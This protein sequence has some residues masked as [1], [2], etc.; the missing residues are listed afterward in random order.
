MIKITDQYFWNV[1]FLIFFGSLVVMGVIILET[2]SRF[3]AAGL[4]PL[5]YI[6]MILATWRLVRLFGYDTITKFFRE[7]FWDLK[8]VG[9]GYELVK[10]THGPRR[11]IADL[12]GCPSC[13]SMWM[14]STTIFFYM[15]TPYAVVPVTIL[16]I[17]AVALFLQN[18][19]TLVAC[20][21]EHI[22]KKSDN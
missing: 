6:L 8:K 19:G 2:E 13:L 4:Q 7:Q 17:S 1:V 20:S 11:T 10:P 3:L 16:A 15:L 5:D 14:A 18:L 21:T 22:S 12:I 9:K